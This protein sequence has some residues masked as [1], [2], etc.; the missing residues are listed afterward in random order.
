MK[1]STRT[2]RLLLPV[3]SGILLT[4]VI[5]VLPAEA[6]PIE[7]LE[8][9]PGG[10]D[11]IGSVAG[12]PACTSTVNP[13]NHPLGVLNAYLRPMIPYVV[14]VSAGL[15]VLMIVLGGLQIMISG[16]VQNAK[17][18][19]DHIFAA[20]IGLMILIFSSTILYFLNASFFRQ[21]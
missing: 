4:L 16:G 19:K 2:Y 10:T 20:L 7:L 14:G 18:G 6:G 8:K 11:C 3:L 5:T 1:N 21:V 15:A 9:L 13:G 17:W 12:G